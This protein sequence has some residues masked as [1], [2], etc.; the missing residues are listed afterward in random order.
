MNPEA[1]LATAALGLGV[2]LDAAT[3]ARLLR[4]V[5][6]LLFW[7]DRVNLTA[8]RDAGG[9]VQK[10]LVDSLSVAPHLPGRPHA[11]VDVGSGAGFPGAVLAVVRPDLQ[12]T[13][14]ES[15]QKKAAFLKTL[16]RELGLARLTVIAR[17][18]ETLPRGTF[19]VATSRATLELP[20]WLALGATLVRPGGLVIG[21]EGARRYALPL[22]AERREY[23]I[24][25]AKR[26][27]VLLPVP[28][29]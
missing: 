5:E 17:R 2:A 19:D 11:L 10:H 14:V 13:L 12:V 25:G 1:Q 8:I 18:A 9:V 28:T 16:A 29:T 27:L 26:A 7:N 6:L 4:Y 22:G 3:L 23:Q 15:N 21:M 24:A 20:A